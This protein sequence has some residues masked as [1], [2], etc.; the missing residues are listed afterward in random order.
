MSYAYAYRTS[1]HQRKHNANT[2]GYV[3]LYSWRAN[4]VRNRNT[5][6]FQSNRTSPLMCSHLSP[7][8]LVQHYQPKL[9]RNEGHL[10]VGLKTDVHT[11]AG[12]AWESAM[13]TVRT[14][15]KIQ[16]HMSTTPPTYSTVPS[17]SGVRVTTPRHPEYGGWAWVSPLLA[18][19]IG[20]GCPHGMGFEST[21]ALKGKVRGH[22]V[23]C[24]IDIV[25]TC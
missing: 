24:C 21:A 3:S 15:H 12:P 4:I 20:A 22:A 7:L 25:W 9:S 11:A 10:Q 16:N 1:T 13:L 2:A 18:D 23:A 6:Q 17:S 14:N 5:Q 8:A 19:V